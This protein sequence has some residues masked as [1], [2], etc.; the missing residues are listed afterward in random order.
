MTYGAT[1]RSD[2]LVGISEG[3]GAVDPGSTDLSADEFE[4]SS[5]IYELFPGFPSSSTPFS[6]FDLFFD[7]VVLDGAEE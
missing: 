5:T 6:D 2:A 4:S 7:K 1:A 3:G